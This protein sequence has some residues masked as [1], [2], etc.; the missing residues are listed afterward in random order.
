MTWFNSFSLLIVATFMV[1]CPILPKDNAKSTLL[2]TVGQVNLEKYIGLW[3]EIAK[4][5]NSFQKQCDCGTTAQ[6]SLRADGRINV[7][8]TCVKTNGSLSQASGV[9]R[10]ID[11]KS[12][13]KIKVSFVSLF[14]IHLFWGDYWIIG[15]DRDYQW[16]IVG[17]PTRKYGWI[18]SRSPQMSQDELQQLFTQLRVQGYHPEDFQLTRPCPQ[19]PR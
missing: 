7:V 13:S 18:L 12:N 4:I 2:Q 8:N 11:T 1:V 17:N 10:V 5:P 6:Y 15:L 14:G 9:A 19:Q 3:Y 16:A